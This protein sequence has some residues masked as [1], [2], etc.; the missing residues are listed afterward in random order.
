MKEEHFSNGDNGRESIWYPR[1]GRG[2]VA[3][4]GKKDTRAA[5]LLACIL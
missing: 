3:E 1:R 5:H 4:F 2:T